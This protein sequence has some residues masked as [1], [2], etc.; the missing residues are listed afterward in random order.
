MPTSPLTDLTDAALRLAVKLNGSDMKEEYD[1]QSIQINHSI[2]KISFAELILKGDVNIEN[3]TM[4]ITDGDDF[5]PGV[6]I[7]ILAG[8]DGNELRSIFKGLIVKHI[9]EL[10]IE[11]IFTFKIS[12][13]HKA[14]KMTFNEQEKGVE[15]MTDSAII[16][17]I[18]STY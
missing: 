3:G 4:P 2:N 8:Y 1:I 9:V 11:S 10:S 17:A 7:E 14:V 6:E 5:N 16:K 18:I 12:C 13:K 15:N